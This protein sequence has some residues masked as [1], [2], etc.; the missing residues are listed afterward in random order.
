[1]QKGRV[2]Y[3]AAFFTKT[4]KLVLFN[5]WQTLHQPRQLTPH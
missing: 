4:L 1:M 3:Y 2:K 5:L